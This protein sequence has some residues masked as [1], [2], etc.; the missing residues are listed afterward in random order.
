MKLFFVDFKKA[1]NNKESEEEGLIETP[2][3]KV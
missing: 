3:I 1:A 2:G